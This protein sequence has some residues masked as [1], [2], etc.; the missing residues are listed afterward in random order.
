MNDLERLW[1]ECRL[2]IQRFVDGARSQ[3]YDKDHV[4]YWLAGHAGPE[5]AEEA[6]VIYFD[7]HDR[8]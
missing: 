1:Q 5:Y 7:T 4:I 6:Q 3:G 8:M 2:D